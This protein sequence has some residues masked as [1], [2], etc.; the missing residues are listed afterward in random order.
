MK[1]VSDGGS[2]TEHT[3]TYL[4]FAVAVG[5]LVPNPRYTRSAHRYRSR[6]RSAPN[7]RVHTH[8]SEWMR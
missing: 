8:P 3:H 2:F 6:V 7:P 4:T 1:L 5:D